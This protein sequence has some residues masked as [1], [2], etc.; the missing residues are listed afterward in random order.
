MEFKHNVYL[1]MLSSP[2]FHSLH[3]LLFH[4]STI[5]ILTNDHVP[6]NATQRMYHIQFVLLKSQHILTILSGHHQ[7]TV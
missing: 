7:V 2:F 1:E 6:F 5:L 4:S 3:L